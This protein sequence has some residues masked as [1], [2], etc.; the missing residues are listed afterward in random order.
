MSYF[1]KYKIKKL[2][3]HALHDTLIMIVIDDQLIINKMIG[4]TMKTYKKMQEIIRDNPKWF[5]P[6]SM[7]YF[8]TKIKSGVLKGRYFI[9]E[10]THYNRY[11]EGDTKYSIREAKEDEII[12]IGDF[13]SFETVKEAKAYLKDMLSKA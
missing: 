8:N 9:T 4:D 11:G 13:H 10:E 6:D 1:K 12:T 3:E 5:S 7:K 2:A